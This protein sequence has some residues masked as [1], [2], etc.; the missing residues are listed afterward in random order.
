M[1]LLHFFSVVPFI[2]SA[3]TL[4]NDGIEQNSQDLEFT[5]VITNVHT[6]CAK[7]ALLTY[8]PVSDYGPKI[9][10]HSRIYF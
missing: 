4:E 8:A 7:L 1:K 6:C 2:S 10:S 9:A 5:H 3:K